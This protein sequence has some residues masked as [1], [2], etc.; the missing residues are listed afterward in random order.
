MSYGITVFDLRW[1]GEVRC[2]ESGGPD[3]AEVV[4]GAAEVERLGLVQE[5]DGFQRPF[6]AGDRAGGGSK[7]SWR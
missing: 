3:A 6:Q 2:S 4:L 1:L 7:T 5:T